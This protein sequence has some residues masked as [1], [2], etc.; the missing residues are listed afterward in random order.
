MI[1]SLAYLADQPDIG[2]TYRTGMDLRDSKIRKP[3]ELY[4]FTNELDCLL[5]AR[6]IARDFR[7]DTFDARYS[8]NCNITEFGSDWF[9][10]KTCLLNLRSKFFGN[11]ESD[12]YQGMKSPYQLAHIRPVQV[13]NLLVLFKLFKR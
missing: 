11:A 7:Y 6:L 9:L 12:H 5:Q 2:G 4:Y 13:Q 3:G 10:G 8:E 1:Q